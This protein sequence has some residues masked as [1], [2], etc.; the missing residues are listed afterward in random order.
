M[1]NETMCVYSERHRLEVGI[2][3]CPCPRRLV[4]AE[5][6]DLGGQRSGWNRVGGRT[7]RYLRAQLLI[8]LVHRCVPDG[9]RAA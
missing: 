7:E 1:I 4:G 5:C 8:Q 6:R 3:P 2:D 9:T